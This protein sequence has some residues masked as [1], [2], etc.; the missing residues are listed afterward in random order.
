M[1]HDDLGLS[2]SFLGLMCYC[3]CFAFQN[4]LSSS[5]KN[6]VP[7]SECFPYSVSKSRFIFVVSGAVVFIHCLIFQCFVCS[8]AL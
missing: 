8:K 5:R 2:Y 3:A 7:A 1:E 6:S 4:F